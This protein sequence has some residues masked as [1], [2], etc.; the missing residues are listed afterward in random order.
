MPVSP[1]AIDHPQP[2]ALRIAPAR[3][4]PASPHHPT[5]NLP[6]IATDAAPRLQSLFDAASAEIRGV[7]GSSATVGPNAAHIAAPGIAGVAHAEGQ[8]NQSAALA[9]IGK[10]VDRRI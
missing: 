9:H 6:Q 4:L 10:N 8:Q 5:S 7:I 1:T 2:I 3:P